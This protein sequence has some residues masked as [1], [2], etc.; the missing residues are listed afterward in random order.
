MFGER[1]SS[2]RWSFALYALGNLPEALAA[3]RDESAYLE[4]AGETGQRS[5]MLSFQGWLL[6]L[7]GQHEEALRV[8][9]EG[10]RTGAPDDAVTQMIWRNAAGLA[11]AEL[12]NLAEADRITAEGIAVAERTDSLSAADAWEA[13]ARVLAIVGRADEM[14]RAAERAR[15]LHARKGSVHFLRRLDEF[16]ATADAGLATRGA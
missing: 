13:R 4:T 7:M 9:E 2:F 5:T 14:R 16:L 11:N 1:H 6:A 10:R 3:S 15:E 12:G 8:A